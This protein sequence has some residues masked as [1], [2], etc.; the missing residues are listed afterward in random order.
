MH[1]THYGRICP[2]ETPEGPNIGLI[3][4]LSSYARINEFGFIESPYRKVENGFV[5]DYVKID[6]RRR[7]SSRPVRCVRASEADDGAEGAQGARVRAAPVLPLRVGGGPVH[8][9]A[10]QRRGRRRRAVRQRARQRAPGGQLHPR[11]AREHPVHRRL[12]EAARVGG[13]LADPVPRE[14]RREPRADGQQH[15]APGGAAAPRQGPVRGHGHG[16]HHGPRLGRRDARAS[17][18][19][20]RL[21]RQP[22][23]R[24]ARGWRPGVERDGR[25]HLQPDQV[26]AVQPE[27]LHQPAPDRPRRREGAEGA[28]PGRRSVHGDG[29]ARARPQRAGRVHALARLQLRGR[30]PRL[31][32][33][34]EGGLL[35]LHPHRGVRDRGPRH[36]ARARGNHARHP[37]CRRELPA[38]PRRE[39]HHPHRRLRQ[40]GRHPGRQGHAEGRDP[41]DAGREA[42]PRDLRREG[43]RREGRVADLPAGHRGDRRRRQDLLAQGHREGRSSQGH[44]GRRA[45]DD[46][47]EPPGR[48]PHSSRRGEEARDRAAGRPDAPHRPVRPARSAAAREEGH[49]P[50]ARA[51]ERRAVPLA[52]AVAHR[53]QRPAPRGRAARDRGAHRPSGRGDARGLRGEEGEDPPRRRTAAGRDQAGQGLRRHE[54]QAVG[55]RQDGRPS[56]QQGRHR[57]HPAG[58]GHAVPAGRT[59][60]GDRAEPAG[61]AVAHERR[62]DP[63]DAPRL[64]RARHRRAA[65]PDGQGPAQQRG[66]ARRASPSSSRRRTASRPSTRRP[67]SPRSRRR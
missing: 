62:A 65:R 60:G 34:G 67:R 66:R 37:E 16:V 9:R 48:N 30:H 6:D 50:D 13:G 27:H 33:A 41:A 40:A 56:R 2:I 5:V 31:R 39:R 47:E 28:G 55:G 51:D 46:G 4:S 7:A 26:Q 22:A 24:R 19:H 36:Q 15:A 21:R 35:H 61:R 43:R 29:R 23:H 52:G 25:R 53:G 63:R 20:R 59:S 45:R 18:R 64:G 58:R 49:R 38:R 3:S 57:A 44:R 8:H 12:A 32:E 54:A 14:R 42:A 17:R 1:P 11:A 10:G